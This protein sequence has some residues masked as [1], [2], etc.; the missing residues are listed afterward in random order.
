MKY[1][2]VCFTSFKGASSSGYLFTIMIMYIYHALI[3]ALSA[4]SPS[5]CDRTEN[6]GH[7]KKKL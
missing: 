5:V 7:K 6:L 4:F 3:N 2:L 1:Y